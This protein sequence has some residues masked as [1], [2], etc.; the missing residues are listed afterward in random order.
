MKR[1]NSMIYRSLLKNC[2]SKFKLEIL[3]YC[4][5]DILI[6]REQ[7]YLDRIKPEYNILK[8]AGSLVG[9]K[10]SVATRELMSM[11]K[12]NNSLSEEARLKIAI[13]INKGVYTLIYNL[14]T[15]EIVSFVSI[16]KA[17]EF[18]KVHHS[19][20]AKFIQLNKF[21]SG[22]GYLVYRSS[23]TADEIFNMED[24]KE[25]N[26]RRSSAKHTEASKEL[27]RKANTGKTLSLETKQKL[28]LNSKNAKPV[29]VTNSETNITLE[30]ASAV[31]AG[32]FLGVDE[33]YIRRCIS[34]NKPCKGY[35]ISRK[36]AD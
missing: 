4:E 28:S 33:S 15:G 20:L 36:S 7:Y 24:S 22:K 23:I 30:F 11:K 13:A 34:K 35:I 19:L 25:I 10:H 21:Y 27:I 1:N 29:L 12:M 9:F 6:E 3:E 8:K 31:A 2:Y 26:I 5:I 17:A 32:K 16:R 14:E 18:I